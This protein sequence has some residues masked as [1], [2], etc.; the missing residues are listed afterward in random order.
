M[1][2]RGRQLKAEE[3]YRHP[4]D[5]DFE[6]NGLTAAER[7]SDG[8]LKWK[9][10]MLPRGPLLN[11]PAADLLLEY[12]TQGTPVDCGQPWSQEEIQQA[13]EYGAH[14]SATDPAAATELRKEALEREA[15]GVVKIV[16]WDDIKDN[17]PASLKVSPVA[18]IPH[19]SRSFRFI[20]NLSHGFVAK[21]ISALGRGLSKRMSTPIPF[22]NIAGPTLLDA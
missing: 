11:H 20:L 4:T 18:A 3:I 15:M 16:K 7:K 10:L 8:S 19:K 2:E 5:Q 12:S 14:P 13:I 6:D 9:G 22:F 1:T 21:Q 17:P